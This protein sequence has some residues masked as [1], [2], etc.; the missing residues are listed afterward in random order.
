MKE[1]DFI[2]R[3]VFNSAGL[4]KKIQSTGY[5]AFRVS[6]KPTIKFGK[7]Y[8]KIYG[9]TVEPDYSRP[10]GKKNK[11]GNPT[12]FGAKVSW[13]PHGYTSAKVKA[14]TRTLAN[15]KYYPVD[16]QEAKRKLML[17]KRKVKGGKK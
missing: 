5:E 12:K 16:Q 10:T 11:F 14:G 3:E 1:R 8:K 15:L 9:A 7:K 4:K 6:S 17:K 2:S 13:H